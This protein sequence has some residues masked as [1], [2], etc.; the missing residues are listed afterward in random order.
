MSFLFLASWGRVR[1][2][3][4]VCV[5]VCVRVC[6]EGSEC[7]GKGLS[8]CDDITMSQAH[9]YVSYPMRQR[10]YPKITNKGI[11][12]LPGTQH[13]TAIN[14]T[15]GCPDNKPIVSALP[16]CLTRYGGWGC[17]GLIPSCESSC[18]ALLL[19]PSF[20]FLCCVSLSSSYPLSVF[21]PGPSPNIPFCIV[22]AS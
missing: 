15:R 14:L 7:Q 6:V 22:C 11:M 5:C 4:C 9:C 2:C 8:L 12:A 1:E 21:L 16:N 13:K 20:I 18:G 19:A 17:A 10:F 3:V